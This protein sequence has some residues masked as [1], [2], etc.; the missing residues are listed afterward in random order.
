MAYLIPFSLLMFGR[1]DAASVSAQASTSVSAVVLPARALEGEFDI[2]PKHISLSQGSHGKFTVTNHSGEIRE[3]RVEV[4]PTVYGVCRLTY[5]PKRVALADGE[6]QVFR[7]FYVTENGRQ[8]HANFRVRIYY[9]D[10]GQDDSVD[11]D[12]D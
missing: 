10:Y 1:V 6:F 3:I 2:R 9:V 11:V 5:S 8:C 7:L 4:E 12:C